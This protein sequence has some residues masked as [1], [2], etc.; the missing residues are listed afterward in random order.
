[1][2]T[3]KEIAEAAR[4]SRSTVQR[5]LTEHPSISRASKKRILDI[6]RSLG[7]RP[8]RHARALVMS[9]QKLSYAA[10]LTVPENS[11][12]REVL[13]GINAA[14]EELR[15]SGAAVTIH[16]MKTI[17]GRRQA[18]LIDRLVEQS[19]KGVVLI[20][21]DCPEVRQAIAEGAARGTSF[22]TL[23]TDIERS[24][25]LCFVGQD[26]R[27]SGRVAGDLM[28]FLLARGEKIACFRGSSQFLGHTERLAGFRERYL[29]AHDER[30]LVEVVENFD[31]ARLSERLTRELFRRHPDLRG[32]FIAG[33]GVEG[34]CRTVEKLGKAGRVRLVTYDLVQSERWLRNG[35]VDFVIDQDPVQEGIRALSALNSWVL[36][37]EAPAEKQLMKIDIRIRDTADRDGQGTLPGGTR[38][39]AP[40]SAAAKK[41]PA[42]KAPGKK[43]ARRKAAP[44]RR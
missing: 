24:R 40:A 36:Y 11:F 43:A 9:R 38:R 13:R 5:A 44:R 6:A 34:V 4:V 18:A 23:A 29:Q 21:V 42:S 28:S 19:V 12:M 10:I 3:A 27:R 17:D 7:Y 16:F 22:V 25:R 14:G 31:S 37:G 20:P 2:V 35:T 26:N 30:D 1:V 33:A 15:D 39:P 8:N 41:T 32:I